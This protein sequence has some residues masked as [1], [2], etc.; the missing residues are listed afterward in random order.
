M[1]LVVESCGWVSRWSG[2]RS[3][4]SAPR[5]RHRDQAEAERKGKRIGPLVTLGL[6]VVVAAV[7]LA[8]IGASHRPTA[9]APTCSGPEHTRST[10]NGPAA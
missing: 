6:L 7:V 2:A 8:I 4:P 3:F 1:S 5:F 9:P 10:A